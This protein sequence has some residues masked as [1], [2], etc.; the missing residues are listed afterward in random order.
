M[1]R[2]KR[3]VSC[4]PGSLQR[5]RSKGAGERTVAVDKKAAKRDLDSSKAIYVQWVDAV[6]D[7]GWEDEVKAEIHLCH[8]IGFLVSE[9]ADALCIA[10]T[11]SKEDSNARMHIPKAWIKKRKVIKVETPVSKSK[12]KKTTAVGERP[13]TPTI[14]YAEH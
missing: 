9:T 10:S 11:V 8:T 4:C 3:N 5:R 6:A 12:R 2:R 14:P 13:D 7:S 1:Q